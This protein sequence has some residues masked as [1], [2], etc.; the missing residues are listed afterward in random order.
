[1][2]QHP[3][4]P[5]FVNNLINSPTETIE[6]LPGDSNEKLFNEFSAIS[7]LL[8]R[9]LE[10][11]GSYLLNGIGT[12]LKEGS[13]AIKFIPVTA[14]AVFTPPVRVERVVRQ[15]AKHAILVGDQQTTN[16][17]MTEFYNEKTVVK[18]RWWVWAAAFAAIAV[19]ALA[20][21]IYQYGFNQLAN[22]SIK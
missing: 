22:I 17:E 3:A 1:M 14:D 10:E 20:V 4:K 2:V 9:N 12:F 7:E 18:S 8:K 13:D 5:E 11:K 15:D 16:T 19:T 21:Y 6:F